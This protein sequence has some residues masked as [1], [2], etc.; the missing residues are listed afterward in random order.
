MRFI[1]RPFW[2]V[3]IVIVLA[4]CQSQPKH[5][6]SAEQLRGTDN[7]FA[8]A[9]HM[10]QQANDTSGH[11]KILLMLEAAELLAEAGDAAWARNIIYTLPSNVNADASRSNEIEAR[12]ALVRSLIAEADGYYPL[13][14]ENIN[15]EA[16]LSTID[17]L[18]TELAQKLRRKR[19]EYL[20]GLQYYPASVD[21]RIALADLLPSDADETQAQ[22]M[23][24]IWQTLMEIPLPQ[25][26]KLADTSKN[27]VQLGWYT[28]AQL[29]KNNQT[30]LRE[31]V[32]QVDQWVRN[33]PEHP[34]SFQLPA[35][36]QLLRQLHEDR[37]QQIALLMPRSG[38][39]G[40]AASAIRDGF[41][42]AFYQMQTTETDVPTLRFYDTSEGDIHEIYDRAVAEGA[43]LVIGPLSKERIVD[44]ALRVE[45]PVPTLALNIVDTPLGSVHNLY[46]FGLAVE[47]EA[48]QAADKAWHDGH[49][50]ALLIAPNTVWGDRSVKA[51]T[52]VWHEL[53]GELSQDYR[54]EDTNDYSKVIK[55]A[56][57]LDLS[58]ARARDVR[59]I[60]GSVEFEPRR[61]QDVDVIF[62]AAQANQARQV[63]PT[64]A[65]HYAGDIPVYA[66]SH[67]YSGSPE[68]KLDQDLNAVHFSTLPWFFND[69]LPE[70]QALLKHA[71]TSPNLQPLY[72]LGVDAFHLY[73]RL[74]QL[75]TITPA[76]YYGQTGRLSL[77]DANQIQRQ[78]VWAE[79]AGGYPRPLAETD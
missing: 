8:Q 42:S 36:L 16:L 48:R 52:E 41:M 66:T 5:P 37:A 60:V 44:L 46:Q 35:D 70:R 2:A 11:A 22:N 18:P 25:L 64:L 72:A 79:F 71:E 34:A 9:E 75:A 20:F 54:F 6:D 3:A 53:G 39:L 24:A 76:R 73:P 77:N 50:R 59:S 65:F 15:D 10:L 12:R 74:Q 45:M 61:R 31:Q 57:Q 38:S 32:E 43:Q 78:Q 1:S 40:G 58:E 49:R 13:A 4:A 33:W 28:L 63:K 21:E 69:S 68:P 26:G 67:I 27:R 56:L 19:A 23:E 55:Q 47:D 14:Y 30:N 7:V 17:T 29:S 51:F 62:L